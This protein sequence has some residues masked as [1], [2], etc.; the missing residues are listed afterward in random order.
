MGRHTDATAARGIFV[1]VATTVVLNRL[2]L[3]TT[4]TITEKNKVMFYN[5]MAILTI[6]IFRAGKGADT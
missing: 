5:Y 4:H 1:A 3:V 6:K 2:R